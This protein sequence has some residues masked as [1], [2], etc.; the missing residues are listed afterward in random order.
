MLENSDEK[1]VSAVKIII[2]HN[3]YPLLLDCLVN[4]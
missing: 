2:D 3:I 1:S 4:G